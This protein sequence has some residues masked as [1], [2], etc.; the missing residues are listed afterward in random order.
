MCKTQIH[1]LSS[2]LCLLTNPCPLLKSV[3]SNKSMYGLRSLSSP[4]ICIFKQ[5][6]VRPQIHVLSSNLCLLT[7]L[8]TASDPCPLLKSMSSPQICVSKQI[9]VQPQIHVLS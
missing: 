7:N 6:H 8:C 3:S 4:Q 9:H 1:V 5:I 2:N